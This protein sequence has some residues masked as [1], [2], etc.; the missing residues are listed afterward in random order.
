M[1]ALGAGIK[2]SANPES[3]IRE[4]RNE[5]ND[6]LEIRQKRAEMVSTVTFLL[7]PLG[8]F[9]SLTILS[10]ALFFLNAGVSERAQAEHKLAAIV[11]SSNDAIIGKDLH[12]IV[13]S[14]N[15][16]AEKIF[17][18][19]AKEMIGQPI[20]RLIPADR[21]QEESVIIDRVGRGKSIEHFETLRQAKDGHL[22]DIS[23]TVSPIRDENGK[24]VGASKV[25][26]DITE[27]K[28]AE[29]A[30]QLTEA[31]Y[32]ALFDYAPDGIV[33]ADPESTYL[34]ANPSICRMLGYT[35][36]EMIGLHASKIVA[37]AEIP[38]IGLALSDIKAKSGHHREWLFRRKDNSVFPAEV[39]ATAM[40]DGNLMGMIRDTTERKKAEE[41][42]RKLNTTL[43]QRV[44]ERT[45][46][47]E[48]ANKEL[49]AFSYSVSHDLR[50]PL[51]AV[52][53]FA[54]AVVEDY[55]PQ[56][57]EEAQRYLQTIREGAQ[58]MGV[59]IDDLL[60]FSRL[61]RS[62]L[63]KQNVNTTEQVRDVLKG[64]EPQREGRMIEVR[65][66]DLPA[67]EGS[68][69]ML[70]HVWMNLLSNAFKYTRLCEKAVVEI[71]CKVESGENVY[72]VRD[73]GTGFD[74]K[75]AHKLFGVFQ[76][77]HRADE[78]EG[79][80]VGLAIV[81]RIIH[82]HGGRIW[83]EA[84]VNRGA[85]FYFTLQARNHP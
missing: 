42:I 32:R 82:R 75:Y 70:E 53:G 55:G 39:H 20:T 26:R 58:R 29:Q 4:M 64:L 19:S 43:E 71:G 22:L 72:F 66:G 2:L 78:F 6:L 5:E 57:P 54:Q 69:A 44:I 27:R 33:I 47:L 73:N 40:P 15:A 23:V 16:G 36:K 18:Y 31:R 48:A 79:T 8:V 37:Q 45:A 25:A 60:A 41:E 38:Q 59:L 13:T 30:R 80:G 74:M 77:L 52:D 35:R 17:G 62:P 81:Q 7:L 50:A 85:T 63:N 51:R 83:V 84:A 12:S 11:N 68:P 65:L 21:Q 61:S 28:Q 67:C 49:E 14:W 46:E 56:L 3:V 34:D 10:L 24:I 9:L 1:L 76:R